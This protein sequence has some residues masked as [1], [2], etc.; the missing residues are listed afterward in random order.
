LSD[1]TI[2]E[3][4][5]NWIEELTKPSSENNNVP[6]CPFAKKAWQEKEAKVV[7]SKD[8]WDSVTKE[9]N[10]FGSHRIVMCVDENPEYEYSELEAGCMALNY[11]FAN[12]GKDIWLLSYQTD[13][14]IVFIQTLSGL[15]DASVI[16][17]KQGYYENYSEDDFKRLVEHRRKL[18]RL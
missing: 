2:E 8:M 15:D 13:R 5:Q 3:W 16:L 6:L 11:W 7:R 12:T 18:R 10:S 1:S 4:I 9:A 14:A 17:E